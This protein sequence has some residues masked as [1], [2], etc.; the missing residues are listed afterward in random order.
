MKKRD[1]FAELN[2]GFDALEA[3][4]ESKKTLRT[5]KVLRELPVAVSGAEIVA[6]RI[7]LNCSRGVF[8]AYMRINERTLEGWEQGRTKPNGQ[9]SLLMRMVEKFPDTLKR[10]KSLT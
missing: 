10:L 4:R 2:E 5:H 8:A 9:A 6:L 3:A 7:K 1:I